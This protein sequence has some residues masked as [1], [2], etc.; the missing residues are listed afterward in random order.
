MSE[1]EFIRRWN[2]EKP[3]YEAWGYFVVAE[4]KAS[5][6]QRLGS[7][8]AVEY[9]LKIPPKPRVKDTASLVDKAYNRSKPYADP[10]NDITDKVGVRFVVLLN[11]EVRLVEELLCANAA[12][13]AR[14]DKDYEAERERDPWAFTY[15]SL[16]YVVFAKQDIEVGGTLVAANTP[17]EVQIRTLL[18]HA[19]SELSHP[20]I[21]KPRVTA[22]SDMV[23]AAARSMA[24]IE[25]ADEYFDQVAQKTRE[26]D[27]PLEEA[28]QSLDAA[29][30][31]HTGQEPESAKSNTFIVDALLELIGDNLDGRLDD[32]V[33][34][35]AYI[36]DRIRQR[37]AQKSLYR[38]SAI[39]LLYL[40]IKRRPAELIEKWPM[41]ATDLRP[42]FVDLGVAFPAAGR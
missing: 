2:E 13:V 11:D 9:F 21:Y 24:L 17:C 36:V 19:H 38:Q 41:P 6:T 29:Y 33:A 39:L 30:R 3:R 42:L 12:W 28:K 20:N 14:K 5:L 8:S 23:R 25:T 34:S 16:H 37:V 27:R 26:N 7:E 18:Q 10:Y 35:D 32:L 1:S 31:K 40:L 4:M 22:S 15:Q